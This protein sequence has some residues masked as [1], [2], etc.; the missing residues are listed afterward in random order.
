MIE[1]RLHGR[2]GQGSVVASKILADAVVLGGG[3]VQAFPEFGVE[4]RGSPVFAFI[5]IDDKPIFLRSKIYEPDHIVV[6]DPTL[7]DAGTI[8][9]GVKKGGIIL[10]NTP[11]RPDEFKLDGD[12]RVMTVDATAIAVKHRLGSKASPIV[13]TAILGAVLKALPVAR[14]D[15]LLEA[16][17]SGVPIKP[18][19]NIAAAKEA[20]DALNT[21]GH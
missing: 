14:F 8:T 15:L 9:E 7:L 20:H 17:R 11:K 2:G 19:D 18:D 21:G 13:N 3:Y 16:I 10:I 1:I 4:R 5:R 6:L 12:F